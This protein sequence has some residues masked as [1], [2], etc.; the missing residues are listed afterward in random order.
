MIP[1]LHW[2][3][4]PLYLRSN[5]YS[6]WW[7]GI[8]LGLG[9]RSASSILASET[10]QC[11]GGGVVQRMG[12][13]IPKTVSSNL[14]RCSRIESAYVGICCNFFCCV[15]HRYLLYLLSKSS[16]RWTGDG[17]QFVGHCGVPGG[18]RGSDQLHNKFM[19]ADS[20]RRRRI[21][22]HLGGHAIE[23]QQKIMEDDAVALVPRLALKTRFS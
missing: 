4:S 21:F 11:N 3:V 15:F 6:D 16:T 5:F 8:T 9:P 17:C 20:S 2:G 13:Q 1:A 14:T 22:G 19:V 12:L 7:N 23:T 10:M 18:L